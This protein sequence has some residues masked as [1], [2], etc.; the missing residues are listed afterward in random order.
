MDGRNVHNSSYEGQ[1]SI[2]WEFLHSFSRLGNNSSW[3]LAQLSGLAGLPS[4]SS[5]CYMKEG[6][7]LSSLLRLLPASEN[8][9]VFF[10]SLHFMLIPFS[11]SW[12]GFC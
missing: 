12:Q 5:F 2:Y 1:T 8:V 7:Y 9:L 10:S 11:P 6:G 3:P 4:E